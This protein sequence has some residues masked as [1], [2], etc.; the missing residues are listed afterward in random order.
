MLV[1]LRVKEIPPDSS[2]GNFFIE[3]SFIESLQCLP[4]F[5]RIINV[6]LISTELSRILQ[7][8]RLFDFESKNAV[9]F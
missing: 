8:I 7:G 1:V 6:Y 3:H 4:T 2:G 9:I 5:R